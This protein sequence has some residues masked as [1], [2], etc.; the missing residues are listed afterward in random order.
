[1]G[2]V[3]GETLGQPNRLGLRLGL[4]GF[5]IFRIFRKGRSV[6]RR[7]VSVWVQKGPIQRNGLVWK[8]AD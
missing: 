2:V 3:R 4:G 7:W 6:I 8:T 1:M 5:G